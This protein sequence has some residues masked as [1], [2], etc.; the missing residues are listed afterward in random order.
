MSTAP[1]NPDAVGKMEA[2][3]RLIHWSQAEAKEMATMIKSGHYKVEHSLLPQDTIRETKE[4]PPAAVVIDLSRLPSQGRDVA[5]NLLQYKSLSNV[6]FIFVDGDPE[7]VAKI[8]S[9]FPD[10]V[11]THRDGLVS[12]LRDGMANPPA[13]RS[14]PTSAFEA[15]KGVPLAKK[16]G[17]ATGK[18]T[19][20]AGAPDNFER[21]L[22]NIPA[23]A[24]ITRGRTAQADLLIWF[25]KTRREMD[26]GIASKIKAL[27]DDGRLWIAWP[28]R[29]GTVSTDLSETIVRETGL[30]RGL[31]DYKIC[32]IDKTWSALLFRKRSFG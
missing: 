12:A 28:K 19:Y 31:V 30:K 23:D 21:T 15:Y 11:Y 9:V 22:G 17:I 18:T 10:L 13:R 5:A 25:S 27:G 24:K 1:T 20:L 2:I 14:R 29:A 3:V 6:P 4:K 8:K 32:S 26:D 16:L 7:K